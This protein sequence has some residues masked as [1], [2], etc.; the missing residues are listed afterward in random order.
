MPY[1][2]PK[3]MNLKGEVSRGTKIKN[4]KISTDSDMNLVTSKI[5]APILFIKFVADKSCEER[6]A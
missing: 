2:N 6:I 3:V 4:N 5:A 1:H